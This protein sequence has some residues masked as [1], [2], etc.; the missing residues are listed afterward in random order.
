MLDEEKAIVTNIAGTPRDLVEGVMQ[1]NGIEVHM[2][3]TAGI[4]ETEDVVEKIGVNRSI[5][6]MKKAD[7]TI[8]VLDGSRELEEEDIKLLI[9]VDEDKTIYLINKNDQK[10]KFNLEKE[11]VIYGNTINL[12]G[13]ESLKEKLILT[14]NINEINKD[15]TYLSNARQIDLIN[16]A[17]KSIKTAIHSLEKGIPVD[18]ISIDLKSCF[19]YL[20]Q[21]IGDTYD[22]AVINRLFA[23]FCVGK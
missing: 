6:A 19:D 18:L 20:G 15:L 4:H 13:L 14:F 8:L 9:E 23:D 12:D 5:E 16:K 22:D 10:I 21:I 2:I 7:I 3:D 1:I 11:N 17:N